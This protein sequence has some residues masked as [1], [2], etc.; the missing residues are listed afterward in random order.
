MEEIARNLLEIFEKRSVC[1]QAYDDEDFVDEDEEAESESLLIGSAA[2]LVAALCGAIGES[3]SSY[4]DVFLP[5][6][7]KYYVSNE[8]VF[9]LFACL[10]A[11]NDALEKEHS[12]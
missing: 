12:V 4:F 6:I 5:L 10:L 1:Q 2:D 11:G 7:S 9:C 3:F 8:I